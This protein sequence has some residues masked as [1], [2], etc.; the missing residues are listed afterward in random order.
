MPTEGRAYIL[1]RDDAE[2]A[3]RIAAPALAP[4]STATVRAAAERIATI[5]PRDVQPAPAIQGPLSPVC[6]PQRLTA[7]RLMRKSS[8]PMAGLG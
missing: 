2:S 3:W 4:L 6:A 7:W 1:G 5:A 8:R